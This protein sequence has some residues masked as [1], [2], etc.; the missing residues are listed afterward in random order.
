MDVSTTDVDTL[1]LEQK[2]GLCIGLIGKAREILFN[3]IS[4]RKHDTRPL[5]M[6]V[7][8]LDEAALWLSAG[9]KPTVETEL[10]LVNEQRQPPADAPYP[11]EGDTQP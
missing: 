4:E 1:T 10:T 2:Q 7:D 8:K 3:E 9:Y 11:E 6:A 5:K